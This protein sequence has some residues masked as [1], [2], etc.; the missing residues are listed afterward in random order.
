MMKRLYTFALTIICLVALSVES[1]AIQVQV[2]YVFC[3]MEYPAGGVKVGFYPT[4]PGPHHLGWSTATNRFGET[5]EV[6]V[7][8]LADEDGLIHESV[9]LWSWGRSHH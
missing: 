7:S 6:T 1:N 5:G 9:N 4:N 3:G 8:D 2:R